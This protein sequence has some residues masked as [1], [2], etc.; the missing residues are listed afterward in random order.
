L[1]ADDRG[2]LYF[3]DIQRDRVWRYTPDNRLQLLMDHNHC[4]TLVLGYDGNVYGENVGGD[5]SGKDDA[6]RILVRTKGV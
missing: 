4:H 1:L 2:T 5:L 6:D 3:C